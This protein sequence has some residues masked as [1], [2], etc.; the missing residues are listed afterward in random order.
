MLQH[1]ERI[2]NSF[3]VT[4]SLFRASIK[5]N[6]HEDQ[7]IMDSV[8]KL[9]RALEYLADNKDWVNLRTM[10]RDLDLSAASTFRIL[11]SLKKLEYVHQ[12]NNGSRY[13]LGM[14]IAGVSASVLSN[15]SLNQIAHPFLQKLTALTNE[16]AHLAALDGNEIVYIDKVDTPQA[17]SMRSRVG[18]HARM[19]TTAVG[20]ATLASLPQAEY[21]QLI[22]KME[23]LP[24]T[25]NTIIELDLFN[26]EI[27]DI[28]GS[29]YSV[30]NEENEIGIRCIGATIYSFS[31]K[32]IGA[33][34]VSGWI[35][36]MTNERATELV[37]VIKDISA[38]ISSA[39]GYRG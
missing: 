7:N 36:T 26:Q 3:H 30:D 23:F 38:K 28:R 19:N 24:I 17:M 11:D 32:V 14:K 10:A 35:I 22:E 13:K 5:Y 15:N 25:P 29:G 27:I 33:V 37:P 21:A 4:T 31:G 9:I 12:E 39:M 16:T 34:S 2:A 18:Q 1:R 6:D 8:T 20:K